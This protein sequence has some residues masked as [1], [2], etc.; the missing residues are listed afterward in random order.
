[1]NKPHGKIHTHARGR[2][3]EKDGVEWSGGRRKKEEAT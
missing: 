2:E 3:E 1:M